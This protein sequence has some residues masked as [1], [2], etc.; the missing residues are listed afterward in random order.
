M[1]YYLL[2]GAGFSRNWG[3]P[4]SE[5]ITGSLLGELHDD[6]GIS[7]ALRQGPFEEAFQ[8]FGVPTSAGSDS[9]RLT[10][11]QNAVTDLF[12]RLNQSFSTRA[13]E[14]N[15]DLEFSVSRFL[16]KFDAISRLTKTS[17]SKYTTPKTS[18]HRESGTGLHF[19][20]CV[21]LLRLVTLAL[22]TRRGAS[23]RLTPA[24]YSVQ[25]FSPF[26][27]Q[28]TRLQQLANRSRRAIADHG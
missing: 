5:E 12:T 13:F 23:G 8:G 10:R 25:V 21:K 24:L 16:S 26:N 14:F 3:G 22:R 7:K 17:C 11:F 6:P 4:L 15:N 9:A 1:G 27:L 2:I 20:E 19:P 28:T 18:S